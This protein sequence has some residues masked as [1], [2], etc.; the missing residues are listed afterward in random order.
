M[1]KFGWCIDD[2]HENCPERNETHRC[3]CDCHEGAG[4]E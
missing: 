4:D 3:G 2:R 1:T